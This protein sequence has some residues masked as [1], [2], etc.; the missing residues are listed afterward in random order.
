MNITHEEVFLRF[1]TALVTGRQSVFGM[2]AYE[3]EQFAEAAEVLTQAFFK[4][5]ENNSNAK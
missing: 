2:S 5:L 1:M 3:A 4:T